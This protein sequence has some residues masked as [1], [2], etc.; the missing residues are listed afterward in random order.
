MTCGYQKASILGWGGVRSNI[1]FQAQEP[2][3]EIS[4]EVAAEVTPEVEAT[5]EELGMGVGE[6][7]GWGRNGLK[8]CWTD[9]VLQGHLED[10]ED[11]VKMSVI[12]VDAFRS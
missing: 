12:F 5:A 7:G 10:V 4:E 11:W 2:K 9:W 3:D 6:E 8:P 1:W